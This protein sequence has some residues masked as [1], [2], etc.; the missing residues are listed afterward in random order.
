MLNDEQ[1]LNGINAALISTFPE[2]TVYVNLQKED[3]DRPSFAILSGEKKIERLTQFLV[4]RNEEFSIIIKE[5][6]DTAGIPLLT[7]L[8]TT[9]HK[10]LETFAKSIAIE[11]RFLLAKTQASPIDDSGSA[12]VILKFDFFD[13]LLEE[14][15]DC[16]FM[17]EFAINF[18]V[19]P[20]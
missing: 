16:K 5:E 20:E 6:L 17:D 8:Q 19:K 4:R 11:D 15:N 13:D 10:I 2:Y 9:Q 7:T 1:M 12:E 14:E 18:K 3:Y